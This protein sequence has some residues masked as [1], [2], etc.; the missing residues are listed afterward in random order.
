MRNVTVNFTSKTDVRVECV[1]R[2]GDSS[3]AAGQL[4]TLPELRPYKVDLQIQ[5]P[6]QN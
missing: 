3:T 6:E 5:L 4:L 2:T 1:A